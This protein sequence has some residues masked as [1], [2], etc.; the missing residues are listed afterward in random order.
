M[1]QKRKSEIQS[2]RKTRSDVVAFEDGRR[3]PKAKKCRQ[4][5]EDEKDTQLTASMEM[6]TSVLQLYRIEFCR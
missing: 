2:V 6:E 3:G 1:R 4:P 5:L